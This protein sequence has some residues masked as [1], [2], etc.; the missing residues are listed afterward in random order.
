MEN[1]SRNEQWAQQII[2]HLTAQG[3]RYFCCAP[4]SRSTPLS[5]AVATEPHAE[6]FIHFDER[7]LAFHALGYAKANGKPA[8]ILT[9]SGTAVG[10]LLPAVMEASN[11]RIPLILLTADRPPELRDCG[12]N[13]TCDQVKL[14]SDYVRWQVDLPCPSDE[15]PPSYLASVIAQCCTQA[16]TPL[17]GPVHLNCMLRE[18]LIGKSPAAEVDITR[19]DQQWGTLL[20]SSSQIER[21]VEKFSSL[22]QGVIL[23]GSD[24]R[25]DA[26]AI[27]ALAEKLQWPIFADILAPIRTVG[28]HS[29]LISHYEGILKGGEAE[30]CTSFLQFGNRFVSKTLAQW[31]GNQRPSFYLHVSAHC[32]VQDPLHQNTHR[33]QVDPQSFCTALAES[34]PQKSGEWPR[35]WKELDG[36]CKERF[37][38]F[39]EENPALSELAAFQTLLSCLTSNDALFLANSMPVR[40]ANLLFSTELPSGPLFGNRGV[41]GIDG[42]IATAAGIAQGCGKRT[43]ALIGDLTLLHDVGS[44]AMLRKTKNPV[45][46]IVINNGGGGIFSFLP[47]AQRECKSAFEEFI[48]CT[49]E[50]QFS[51]AAE[52]FGLPYFCPENTSALKKCLNRHTSCL[53]EICTD[54]EENAALH[55]QLTLALRVCR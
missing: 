39:F 33:L 52:L 25:D 51:A 27:L 24:I 14:F 26:E 10:N 38:H 2:S 48:V 19:I 21:W 37:L 42:N 34:L 49:H 5:L 53:I 40:D 9:T 55:E 8:V 35:L 13:Q 30:G 17:P 15:L 7:A 46:L 12:A 29:H 47:I 36:A 41:S 1:G 28:E 23:C 20:P 45:I 50:H 31:I 18:P 54:R 3:A 11:E 32:H 43:F 44:L 22:G 16:L 6:Y 4:G